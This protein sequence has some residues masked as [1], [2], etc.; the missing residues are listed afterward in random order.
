M[1]RREFRFDRLT[2][3][4][5]GVRI[6]FTPDKFAVIHNA[7][8]SRHGIFEYRNADG[9]K[10]RE[11]R[12][13][14]VVFAKRS[15]DSFAGKP[16]TNDHPTEFVK[17]ETFK[18]VAAGSL[19]DRIY[20]DVLNGRPVLRASRINVHDAEA[21]A[22]LRRGKRELSGGYWAEYD[23]TPG[24]D[25]DGNRFD[26]TQVFIEGNHVALVTR[27]RAG[28]VTLLPRIDSDDGSPVELW[29]AETRDQREFRLDAF[30]EA[31]R[32]EFEVREGDPPFD[33]LSTFDS[34]AEAVEEMSRLHARND[35][36]A[37]AKGEAAKDRWKD[38]KKTKKS[39]KED[40]M[41]K[42]IIMDSKGIGHEVPEG[43]IG[44]VTELQAKGAA[45]KARADKA[46]GELLVAKAKILELEGRPAFDAEAMKIRRKLERDAEGHLP[47]EFKIDEASNE[48]IRMAVVTDRMDGIDLAVKSSEFIAGMF[49]A[50]ISQKGSKSTPKA[51]SGHRADSDPAPPVPPAP[52]SKTGDE[53]DK[54]GKR[55][56]NDGV[57]RI[58]S[59]SFNEAYAAKINRQRNA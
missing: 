26:G 47:N 46:E 22:A 13:E 32:G 40:H 17:P 3:D 30:I 5:E 27:G 1:P 48:D 11:Y 33:V 50:L 28:A 16:F 37:A 10:R 19:G 34:R 23:P 15:M 43:L 39:D 45:D 55:T 14:S 29:S 44:L 31:A 4:A 52:G 38:W 51:R 36:R 54:G 7:V 42:K 41:P 59:L 8:I 56:D 21:I 9:T 12:P 20:K 53:G 24:V 58:D 18:D 35:P 6:E 57:T 25:P 49:N 2:L